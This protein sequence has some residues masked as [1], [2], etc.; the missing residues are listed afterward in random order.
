MTAPLPIFP[1]MTCHCLCGFLHPA[2]P[3]L[4]TDQYETTRPVSKPDV[5]LVEDLPLRMCTPC[6]Q[7]HD[8][9]AAAATPAACPPHP[10]EALTT[11]RAGRFSRAQVQ[12]C[13]RCGDT[14]VLEP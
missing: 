5:G 6:A 9:R 8:Q 4:C 11:R 7:A 3:G 2:Q 10:S 12:T 1:G 13:T 14:Q